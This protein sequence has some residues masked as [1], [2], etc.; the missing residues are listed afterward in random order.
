MEFNREIFYEWYKRQFGKLNEKQ[1]EGLN[2]LLNRL[3]QSKRID[4]LPKKAYVLATIYFET[5]HTFQPIKEYGSLE[6]L[7]SKKYYPYY[8]RGY[9]QLTWKENYKKFGDA[10]NIDLVNKPDLALVPN[11]SWRIL[12]IGMTDTQAGLQDPDFT[13]YTLED[14]F[15]N[16]QCDY[17]NARKIIN[18]KDYK[19]YAPISELAQKFYNCFILSVD[20]EEE[21]AE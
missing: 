12:E 3:E 19:T 9:A 18:P 6:Y 15:N 14:F 4:T 8:G 11:I 17:Y 16:N 5:A 21:N 20:F 13:N 10:L 1:V 7:R 2:F